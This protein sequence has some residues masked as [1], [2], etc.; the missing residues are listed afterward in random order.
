MMAAVL[1][2]VVETG[3]PVSVATSSDAV[4]LMDAANPWYLSSCTMLMPTVLMIFLPP[5]AVPRAITPAQSTSIH[6][7]KP[8]TS[9]T[10]MFAASAIATMAV[11]MNFWP[12][13]APCM[14]ATPAAPTTCMRPKKSLARRR[15]AF[16]QA[17][18]MAFAMPQPAR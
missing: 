15:S 1:V 13:W 14:R 4:A 7:G 3:R 6:R 9:E 17:T 5:T 8:P 18:G 10:P 2:C 11:D 16:L 12:S